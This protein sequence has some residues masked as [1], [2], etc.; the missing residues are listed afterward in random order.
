MTDLEL[1]ALF[2]ELGNGT[3]FNARA[4]TATFADRPHALKFKQAA[5][6]WTVR[7][8]H[9]RWIITISLSPHSDTIMA[10]V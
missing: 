8:R 9:N 6:D 2:Y 4:Q 7:Y 3:A 5:T 10:V 1:A